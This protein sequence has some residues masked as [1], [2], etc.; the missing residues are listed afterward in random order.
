VHVTPRDRVVADVKTVK[1]DHRTVTSQL[2]VSAGVDYNEASH[3]IVSSRFGGR[4][5]RLFVDQTGQYVKRGQPLM[6][7]YSPELI[8]AQKEY[9]LA[10]ETPAVLT[11]P[12]STLDD[13]EIDRRR[14]EQASRLI[15]SS[16]KRLELLGMSAAQIAALEKRGEI[17]YST[18]VFSPAEGTV[19]QRSVSEGQYVNE[20]TT[21]LEIIDL[22]TVWVLANVYESDVHRI[23]QGM[24]MMVSGPSLGGETLHGRVTFIYPMVDAQTRT[25]K[26]RGVFSNPGTRLRPGMYLTAT[27]RTD[28]GDVLAVP[29]TSVIRTGVRDIVYVEV[30]KNEFEARDV[31]LGTRHGDFYEIASGDLKAGDM[32]VEQGGY[33][34]DSER[35]LTSGE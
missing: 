27:I 25:V 22:S 35:Q 18:T 14:E 9:L 23:R 34:I 8:V 10:R 33:L 1:I 24:D 31:T 5:E 4:I 12:G 21:L 28:G 30:K 20:G 32:V 29:A 26:V 19:V 15:A 13:P 17:A 3:R 11:M 7:I 2:V 16:R 6:E